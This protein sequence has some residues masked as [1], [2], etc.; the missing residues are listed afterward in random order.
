VLRFFGLNDRDYFSM[1]G[2]DLIGVLWLVAVMGCGS[3]SGPAGIAVDVSGSGRGICALVSGGVQCW[4]DSGVG[5]LKNG[6][7]DATLVPI[8]VIASGAGAT[9]VSEGPAHGCAVV[10][11]GVQCWGYNP[12][13]AL[14]NGSTASSMTPVPVSGLKSNVTTV[15]VGGAFACA[16]VAGAVSCWGSNDYAQLGTDD[17]TIPSLAPIPASKL[18]SGVTAIS[19]GDTVGC[20]IVYDAGYCWGTTLP[21]SALGPAPVD[22]L[23][24]GVAAIS[25]GYDHR[26]AVIDGG[27][28]CW[29][30]NTF[31]QLGNSAVTV[32]RSDVPVP[33]DGLSTGVTAVSAGA[34]SSC[35]IVNGGAQCWGANARGQL[36]YNSMIDS[37][38]P[39]PV[40]GLD[41]GV[42][43]I[44]VGDSH[45]CAV[46]NGGVQC[47][48]DNSLGE[49]GDGTQ[50]SSLVPVVVKVL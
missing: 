27:A 18:A 29:G 38:V 26:C 11:G 34:F 9:A 20:A 21:V 15:S 47:W 16:I 50:R 42:T 48:G 39:V 6:V 28:W 10:N 46:V 8:R 4:G 13:G 31:G 25:A 19:A 35:A 44:S 37:P 22:G 2:L 24:P 23:D 14:G 17:P 5:P 32:D 45:A 43:A 40:T 3:S 33:V 41:A 36:G 49:L 1:P 30:S 7:A 12:T